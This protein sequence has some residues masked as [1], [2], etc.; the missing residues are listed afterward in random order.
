MQSTDTVIVAGITAFI[1]WIVGYKKNKAEVEKTEV[2]SVSTAVKIWRELAQ[3]LKNEVE[4]LR[5]IVDELRVENEKLR[6]EI[7]ELKKQRV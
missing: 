1:G 5:T 3:D 2:D 6:F 7:L 4:E